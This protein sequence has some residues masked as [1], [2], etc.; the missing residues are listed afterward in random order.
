MTILWLMLLTVYMFAF[1]ARYFS[2]PVI[3][4]QVFPKPN[5]L[6][7][8]A[9]AITLIIVSGLRNNIGDTFFYMHA[10]VVDDFSWYAILQKK[11]IGFNV[12]QKFLKGFTDDPQVLIFILAFFTN[13]LIIKVFYNY[14]RLFELAVFVFITSGAFIVSMNGMRQYFAAAI[15]FTATKYMLEGSWKK[16]MGLVLLASVF[17][18]SALIMIPIYF[19]VRRKAWTGTTL[20]LLTVAILIVFGF[21]QFQE[22]LFSTLKDTSYGEY[23]N[24]QEGGANII[25]VLFYGFPL[26]IAFLGRDKLRMLYPQ[27]DVFVNL[28]LIGAVLMIISTQNWIF[29]RMA[30]YFTL[31]QI[32]LVA[33]VIK[34]FRQKDQKL[35]Y[36]V[37]LFIYL[38]FFFY[39]NV[40]TL[41]IQYRSD[42]LTWFT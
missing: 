9:V 42:Y 19:F 3:Q 25:R 41:G 23:Q 10:Y 7:M 40:I 24:F 30:I 18:Q 36:L 22:I 15:I 38:L 17:H 26:I 11:D 2:V 20:V 5:K 12:F 28:S 13:L 33:W 16:Y 34:V 14:A 6:M 27:I 35:I 21:N 1:L 31:Y 39:E 37:L 32:V 29:A 8:F 4:G